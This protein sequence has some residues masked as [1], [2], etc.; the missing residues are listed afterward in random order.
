[1]IWPFDN[2]VNNVGKG[3]KKR[4]YDCTKNAVPF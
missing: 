3:G 4:R 2:A 1:M